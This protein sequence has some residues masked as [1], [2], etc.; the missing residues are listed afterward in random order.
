MPNRFLR[1]FLLTFTLAIVLTMLKAIR[2]FVF[3]ISLSALCQQKQPPVLNFSTE[4]YF[5]G[6]QNWDIKQLHDFIYVANNDGLL[7]FD[8]ITWRLYQLPNKTIIRSIE[9]ANDKIYTGSYEEFGYWQRQADGLLHYTSLTHTVSEES[10]ESQSFWDI[11]MVG[12]KV[13]FKSFA[14]MV[15]YHN[16]KSDI[17][18]PG[19]V[20]LGAK[21]LN[22]NLVVSQPERGLFRLVGDSLQFIQGSE[23]LA[24]QRVQDIV[25]LNNN[26]WLIGTSLNGCYIYKNGEFSLW[27]SPLNQPLKEHQLNTLHIAGNQL[28]AGTIK[29]GLYS[30]N[31]QSGSYININSKHGLQNNTILATYLDTNKNLWL[32]L[33][34]GISVIST[35]YFAYYLNTYKEDIGAVHDMALSGNNLYVATNTGIFRFKNDVVE[36]INGSQGHTWKL[37]NVDGDIVCGHNSGTFIIKNNQLK[38]LSSHNGGYAF[39]PMPQMPN[40]YL[41]GN[42]AGLSVYKKEGANW[43]VQRIKGINFPVK[44][45][46]F[47]K[48]NVVWAA[49]AYKGIYRITLNNNFTEAIQIDRSFNGSFKNLYNINLYSIEGNVSFY[50][51]SKWY[52]YNSLE[53]KIE[54]FQSFINILNENEDS[55]PI[56]ELRRS[57]VVFKKNDGTIFI[58]SKLNTLGS[59]VFI[60]PR[61]YK[62]RL[63]KAESKARALAV[64]DS[65][66]Y[67]A[68]YNDILA[69]NPIKVA[70]SQVAPTPLISMVLKNGELQNLT[71]PVTLQK[72]DTLLVHLGVPLL[73]AAS[74]E[75]SLNGNGKTWYKTDGTIVLT[76]LNY[77]KEKLLVRS[78]SNNNEAGRA[79]AL[80]IE[81]IPPWYLGIWG[82]IG[83]LTIITLLI[84]I[85][86]T[87]NKYV[88]IKH[89]KYLNEQF[90][91]EQE[92]LRKEEAIREEKRMNELLKKQYEIEL[93]AKS[94]ELANTAM[95]MTKK[96]ELLKDLKSELAYF[97]QE[98]INKAKY[99]KMLKII[100]KNLANTKDW[101]VFESNFN[102]IHDSFFKALVDKHPDQ[103]TP[104]D[105]RLCAYLKM[106]LSTKE[107]APLMGISMRGVEI[108]RYRLRK[109]L[110]LDTEQNLNEYLLTFL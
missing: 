86:T 59:D 9:V 38:L 88:L 72:K 5:A 20:L 21:V 97:K 34:N 12:Q 77:G 100:D 61:Y 58:R 105:L 51:E 76:G 79:T 10:I 73:T 91:H 104:K 3:F 71:M 65:L 45:L 81:V 4:Q 75:Y 17:I 28:Y 102:E 78:V 57:P 48:P 22:G 67:I 42:Y 41:Q 7:E 14:G 56:S 69:V 89:K 83:G 108:H 62:N 46:A 27:D 39:E 52:R 54:P 106:N 2:I 94:K 99:E 16:G 32:A 47:E 68:L 40:W 44:Q 60:A 80:D 55:E 19:G 96:N 37:T 6:N 98:V 70:K 18:A 92:L 63:I 8:G 85:I 15:V 1:L 29:N 11:Y 109:K 24:G 103:L 90:L 53:N 50:V 64:N 101:E 35:N 82:I 13:I 31:L 33:D 30:Y 84:L 66:V 49:H 87:I 36:F 74:I 107:I 95:G 26:D 23:K 93:N 110:G 43:Q 25:A